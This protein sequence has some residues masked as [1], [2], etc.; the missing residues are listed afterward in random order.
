MEDY[1]EI[2]NFYKIFGRQNKRTEKQ[3]NNKM[4]QKR[5]GRERKVNIEKSI[6]QNCEEA[7]T[8]RGL[9]IKLLKS[10]CIVL[11]CVIFLIT[12]L[13]LVCKIFKPRYVVC[14][15]LRNLIIF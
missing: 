7:S 5:E 3:N 2:F 9:K 14:T 11:V 4:K 1:R 8:I 6:A 10:H 12:W 13:D 15:I